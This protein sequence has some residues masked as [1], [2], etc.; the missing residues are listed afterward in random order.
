MDEAELKRKIAR[1]KREKKEEEERRKLRGME[2]GAISEARE[3]KRERRIA[4][5]GLA[6]EKA[7]VYKA[8]PLPRIGG[9]E[10]ERVRRAEQRAAKAEA[11][12]RRQI[13]LSQ[14]RTEVAESKAKATKAEAKALAAERGAEKARLLTERELRVARL[15]PYTEAAK[16]AG[17]VGLE[18]GKVGV[19]LGR[20]AWR[21]L[22]RLGEM[23]KETPKRPRR[24][25][26]LDMGID[27]G[28]GTPE[29]RRPAAPRPPRRKA[30]GLLENDDPLGLKPKHE[31]L[32][33]E[34][35]LGLKPKYKEP[36]LDLDFTIR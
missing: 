27:L 21:G 22:E 4:G 33:G 35:P 30:R 13:A 15:K 28:F 12:A 5:V 2:R 29:P 1:L 18:V 17:K 26:P 6:L 24:E 10:E 23:G 8:L 3:A 9:D 19:G 31:L 16:A 7:K 11:E 34:D 32:G 20:T 36:P 25:A 14:R